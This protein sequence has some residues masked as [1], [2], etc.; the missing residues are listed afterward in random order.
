MLPC[1]WESTFINE[2]QSNVLSLTFPTNPHR[3]QG[4]ANQAGS[5]QCKVLCECREGNILS[6][7]NSKFY[8]NLLVTQKMLLSYS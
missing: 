1:E 4:M 7:I 8:S 3:I 2:S 5:I 6:A